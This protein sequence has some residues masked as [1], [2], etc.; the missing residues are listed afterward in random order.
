MGD[1]PEV[2]LGM[3]DESNAGSFGWGDMPTA[4][5]KV[6]LVVGVDAAFQMESQMQVQKS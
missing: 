4:A 2:A 1:R 6:D 3:M 5:K